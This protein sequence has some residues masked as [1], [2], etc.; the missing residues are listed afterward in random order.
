MMINI[1]ICYGFAFAFFCCVNCVSA[2][3]KHDKVSEPVTVFEP[4]SAYTTTRIPAIVSTKKGTLLAFC[5]ARANSTSDWAEIDLIMRRSTNGGKSWDPFVVIVPREKNK[6]LGN[7]TPIVDREGRIHL[8]FQRN[9][10]KAY[11]MLSIDDGV[12]WS[13]PKNITYAFEEFK[14]EYNW[15]VIA[16]GPGHAIQL[17]SGRLL[18]PVW[19]CEPD[20]SISGGHRPSCVATV[21]SDDKGV[22]WKR[23]EII[24]CN[25][26]PFKNPSESVAAELSDGRIMMN[27]RNEGEARRRMISYSADGISHW[28]KPVFD[29]ALY[30]PICMA[31]MI[32]LHNPE[33]LLFVNPDSQH[34]TEGKPSS[35][36][37]R[38]NLTVKLSD[39][40]GKTWRTEKVLEPGNAG[41]SDLTIGADGKIY[42]LYETNELEG[43]KYKIVLKSFTLK[44]LTDTDRP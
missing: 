32:R 24:S 16:P 13:T 23:G 29:T 15:K 41:Y 26:D 8:L 21:Y 10:A 27:I 17:K 31:G 44:W 38:K 14:P 18:V 3:V 40:E 36:Q 1:R 22:T 2:Q 34:L 30:E 7:P 6:P 43:W 9:Y 19:I 11:H 5:E 12:T 39:D 37:R 4:G 35:I 25:N 20:S 33:V 28:T 42:C